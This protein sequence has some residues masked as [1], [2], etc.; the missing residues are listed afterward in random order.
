MNR[1]ASIAV[2]LVLALAA[3]CVSGGTGAQDA[4]KPESRMAVQTGNTEPAASA[5]EPTGRT[6]PATGADGPSAE[7]VSPDD[8]EASDLEAGGKIAL[9]R[10]AGVFD[11]TWEKEIVVE[12]TPRKATFVQIDILPF[13][14]YM[15]DTLEELR[16]ED[17]NEFKHKEIQALISV[18]DEDYGAFLLDTDLTFLEELSIYREYAGT[19]IYDEYD[20][21]H[22]GYT[23]FFWFDYAGSRAL[24][25]LTCSEPDRDVVLP[26][27]LD[28]ISYIQYI[29]E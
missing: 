20:V 1:A 27:F 26:H 18:F 17:G 7:P 28:I 15:P 22:P 14:L 3:G 29:E 13:G 4:E 10:N 23:D 16:F 8:A 19:S 12:G 25:R 5:V 11:G 21:A 9:F 6:E 24:V 2:V